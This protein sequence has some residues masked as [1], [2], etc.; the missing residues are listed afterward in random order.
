MSSPSP[1]LEDRLDFPVAQTLTL[2]DI[3]GR[4]P[5][6]TATYLDVL[7]IISAQN[8]LLYPL[9]LGPEVLQL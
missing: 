1:V 2:P 7:L 4:A 3:P 6:C 5:R 9:H 8:G